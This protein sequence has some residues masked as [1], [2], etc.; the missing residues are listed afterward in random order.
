MM[1]YKKS[2]LNFER[3][4]FINP[5]TSCYVQLENVYNEDKD[6]LKTMVDKNR[7][8]TIFAPRQSGKK[9][10][11]RA[12]VRDLEKNPTYIF[13]LLS[14]DNFSNLSMEEFYTSIENEIYPQLIQRLR[15]IDYPGFDSV[16][17]Y[18]ES[19]RISNSLSFLTL[20]RK[21][22]QLIKFKKLIVFIDEF[23]G[24]PKHEIVD[25]LSSLRKL[26]QDWNLEIQTTI[27]KTD[28]ALIFLS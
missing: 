10:F 3:T 23:D 27:Q 13:I 26:Y 9:I 2:K 11:F 5:K 1:A 8:F 24:I 20:F 16:K 12:F 21:L 18:L 22:N 4:G 25:F 19:H 28:F 6:D 17:N 15:A 14:F 7:Y